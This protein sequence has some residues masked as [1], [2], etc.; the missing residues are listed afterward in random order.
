MEHY[1]FD[2]YACCIDTVNDTLDKYGVAIIPSII[3]EDECLK[4]RDGMWSSIE[5]ITENFDVPMKRDDVSSWQSYPKLFP[6]HS[7]LIQRFGLTSAQYYWDLRQNE[8]ICDVFAKIWDVKRNDLLVSFD[9]ISLHLAPEKTGRGWFSGTNWLHTDLSPMRD[10]K[11]IQSFLTANEIRA[12]DATLAFLEGSHIHHPKLHSVLGVNE[13]DDWY[14][15]TKEQTVYFTNELD[16]PRK[17]IKC[18]AGSLVLWASSTVHSGMEPLKSRPIENERCIIYLCYTERSRASAANLKKKIKAF[19]EK[20]TTSHWP[21][22]PKLFPVHPRTY[23]AQEPNV[24]E[25]PDPVLN[26][27]G[28]RLVGY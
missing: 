3:G 14:K 18:P 4:M 9:G 20:R 2:K 5:K 11:C 25:L 19:E 22:R 1:E 21:H 10:E 16:C 8:S 26:D 13:K 15:L 12:G 17:C 24:V 28:R 27:L 7:M 6:L 23:G